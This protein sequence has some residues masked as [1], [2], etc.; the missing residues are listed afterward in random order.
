MTRRILAA[1]LALTGGLLIGALLPLGF[2]MDHELWRDYRA[3]TLAVA[4]T[5]SS[6]AEETVVDHESTASSD[7]PSRRYDERTRAAGA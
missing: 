2:E 4:H 5:V 1:L 7:P 3:D 6:A